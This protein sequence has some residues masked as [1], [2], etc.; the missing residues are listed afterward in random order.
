MTGNQPPPTRC[1]VKG[2][3]FVGRFLP[4]G[5]CPMHRREADTA[6]MFYRLGRDAT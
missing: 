3:A 6:A 1:L 2:C 4:S 5:L